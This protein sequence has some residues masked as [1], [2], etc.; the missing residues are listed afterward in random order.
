MKTI[1]TLLVIAATAYAEPIKLKGG[2]T[3]EGQVV[4]ATAQALV[5]ETD[6]GIRSIPIARLDDE[7]IQ[8]HTA[9]IIDAQ[10]VSASEKEQREA[11]AAKAAQQK[12]TEQAARDAAQEAEI[13]ERIRLK[14]ERRHPRDLELVA[15]LAARQWEDYQALGKL[16]NTPG[17]DWKTIWDVAGRHPDD[18]STQLAVLTRQVEDA[19][20]IGLYRRDPMV[21]VIANEVAQRHPSDYS[22][23]RSVIE[24]EADKRLIKLPSVTQLYSK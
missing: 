2:E 3:I 18:Y 8:R 11:M 16:T 7:T 21:G 17:M 12:A 20:V 22:T 19:R 6:S 23:Q 15:Q 9:K 24:N 14:I 1:C 5:I 13:K 4:R 10:K